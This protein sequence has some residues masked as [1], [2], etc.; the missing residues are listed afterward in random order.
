MSKY[1][2]KIAPE[3]FGYR[4]NGLKRQWVKYLT[5][6]QLTLQT[7]AVATKVT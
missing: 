6:Q 7:I 2:I 4:N 5:R 3:I 1:I